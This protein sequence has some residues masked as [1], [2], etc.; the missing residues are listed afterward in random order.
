[1]SRGTTWIGMCAGAT[2]ALCAGVTAA[3]AADV[4]LRMKGGDF[5]VSGELKAFDGSKYTIVSKSFGSMSLDAGR[6][7]C[8]GAA[9]PKPGQSV[10]VVAA[11]APIGSVAIAGSNTI[12]GQ[13]MP[14]LV[15]TYAQ[16]QGLKAA[17]VAGPVPEETVIKLT[18]TKG[19]EVGTVDLKRHGSSTAFKALGAKAAD[20]GMS[21]RQVKPDEARALA[22]AGLGDLRAPTHEYVL[23]LDGLALLVASGNPAVSLSIEQIAKIFAGQITNWSEVGLPAGQIQVYS[24]SANNGTMDTFDDLVLKPR[25]LKLVEAAKRFESHAEQSDAVAADKLGI[26]FASIAYQRNAK[27]IN[28]ETSCGLITRPSTFAMKTEEYPLARR[29]YLYTPGVPTKPFAKGLLDFALSPA[30]QPVVRQNDFVDQAP[31]TLDFQ[32]QTARIAYALNA[33][34]AD[35]DLNLMKSLINDFKPAQRLTSTFRFETASFGLD[36]KALADIARLRTLLESPEY[37]GKTVL[38]AGFADGV[39]RFDN[40]L[41]LAQKRAAAVLAAIQRAGTNPI[42]AQLVTKSYS[43]LAPVACNDTPE[44]RTFNRRVEIWV[45]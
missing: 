18:D 7:D 26:G 5:S 28:I 36:T 34:G 44:A 37:R 12:G 20:I 27:A 33:A 10:A 4:T 13:L 29:L 24:P 42:Q 8:E 15:Q 1:M 9:C 45:K 35:F 31:E 11:G 23:G 22:A 19:V 14:A 6:F 3:L 39:G 40:N 38:I 43:Q 32:S 30:A 16:A 41:L 2:L 25:G 17:R 21:S